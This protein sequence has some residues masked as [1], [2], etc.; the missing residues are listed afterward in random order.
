[1][2]GSLLHFRF[3]MVVYSLHLALLF[4]GISMVKPHVPDK[5]IQSKIEKGKIYIYTP[6]SG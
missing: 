4:G 1:M 2:L 5:E 6:Y 3:S